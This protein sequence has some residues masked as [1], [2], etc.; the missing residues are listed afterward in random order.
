MSDISFLL[1]V[2]GL[3]ALSS[4]GELC[5]EARALPK[6][7][8]PCLVPLPEKISPDTAIQNRH[9]DLLVNRSSRDTLLLRDF[10]IRHV[11]AHLHK[12]LG[13]VEVQ[14]PIL[15][16]NAGGAIARAFETDA[17]E[18]PH[19]DL[20][21]RIAPELWL[22]RLVVA[23]IDRVYE[24][25]PSFRN[26]GVDATHNP[27]FTTCEFYL[28]HT[29]LS[30]L[31]NITCTLFY[32]LAKSINQRKSDKFASLPIPEGFDFSDRIERVDFIP[33]INKA[34]GRALPDLESPTALPDLLALLNETGKDWHRS[35]PPNPSLPK[36]LDH[37]AAAV[38][39]P[40][41]KGRALFITHH[42]VC[43]S[44]LAKSF[45]R[46]G[47]QVSARAE[48]FCD[49][50]EIANMYEE[51]NDPFKQRAKFIAQAK[52]RLALL[53]GG[54]VAM[55]DA[56][57]HVIDEQYLTVLEAGLPPTGGWGCGIDRLVMLFSGAK[58]ISDVQPFGNLRHVVGLGAVRSALSQGEDFEGVDAARAKV[59]ETRA[60]ALRARRA[61]ARKEESEALK[62]ESEALSD[63][64]LR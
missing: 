54:A 4:S 64:E 61:M 62:E 33:A 59:R 47:Q 52:A 26:E 7:F 16:A 6:L 63:A 11:R 58:R 56:P 49:G 34:L 5:I 39:E 10:I 36:L 12:V 43:M 13:C 18:F 15:A 53:R 1:A 55:D 45:A 37:I 60:A 27:E 21:L 57:A 9:M 20:S 50:R 28:A 24:L 44:P 38:I 30:A 32:G 23:G 41:S 48:L 8:S 35:L 29:N 3:P 2:S 51:E 25:G 40:Q 14:T 31:M 17:T 22:K 42:P 19:K 46:H